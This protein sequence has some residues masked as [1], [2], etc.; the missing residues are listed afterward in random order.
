MPDGDRAR[1]LRKAAAAIAAAASLG[2]PPPNLVALG[3]MPPGCC[4]DASGRVVATAA[5]PPDCNSPC[6]PTR[7]STTPQQHPQSATRPRAAVCLFP[8]HSAPAPGSDAAPPCRGSDSQLTAPEAPHVSPPTTEADLG[9]QGSHCPGEPS[10]DC[11]SDEPWASEPADFELDLDLEFDAE[12]ESIVA[13]ATSSEVRAAGGTSAMPSDYQCSTV[14]AAA[15]TASGSDEDDDGAAEYEQW[16]MRRLLSDG[17]AA[18]AACAAAPWPVAVESGSGMTPPTASPPGTTSLPPS[19]PLDPPG[20]HPC[21]EPAGQHLQLQGSA[22]LLHSAVSVPT[23]PVAHYPAAFSPG[24]RP[25]SRLSGTKHARSSSM[26]PPADPSCS[27]ALSPT[28]HWQHPATSSAPA[29]WSVESG[30]GPTGAAPC[31]PELPAASSIASA[32]HPCAPASA[33]ATAAGPPHVGH[34]SSSSELDSCPVPSDPSQPPAKRLLSLPHGALSVPYASYGIPSSHRHPTSSS[35]YPQQPSWTGMGSC[36]A[37]AARV[38]YPPPYPSRCPCL[39]CRLAVPPYPSASL[40]LGY[41][42]LSA[43]PYYPPHMTAPGAPSAVP[44]FH[45]GTSSAPWSAAPSHTRHP[46]RQAGLWPGAPPPHAYPGRLSLP[47]AGP[48]PPMPGHTQ[49]CAPAPGPCGSAAGPAATAG[50]PLPTVQPAGA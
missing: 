17:G 4:Y 48:V 32:L 25:P 49:P 9:S 34:S 23:L 40:S 46:P 22:P 24:R 27:N 20:C 41:Y 5:Y 29:C 18:D 43:Y 7:S 8:S 38:P 11:G 31:L 1:V 21:S 12:V 28:R 3:L 50:L 36:S 39:G 33:T 19:A 37:A 35:T 6:R 13:A 26:P 42:G 45:P 2:L 15:G 47:R 10:Q 16:L 30:P 14:E 44:A